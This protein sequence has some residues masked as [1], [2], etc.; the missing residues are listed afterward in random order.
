[1]QDAK[2]SFYVALRSRLATINPE[3]T[4]ML[5]GCNRPGILV[6]EAE[7]SQGQLPSDVFVL[8]WQGMGVDRE[9][10]AAMV[11]LE[12]EILYQTCGHQGFGGLDR[13]R[14]LSCMDEELISMLHPSHTPKMN[15][16]ATPPAAKLTQVFWE[17]PMFGP[18]Q[19]QRDGLSRTAKVMVYSYEEQGE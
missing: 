16:S 11:A 5:R 13:G 1:M 2:D 14:S 12:C 18:V 9:L 8:R 19:V 3:R 10:P 4:V 7:A 6:E 15:Y 17:E